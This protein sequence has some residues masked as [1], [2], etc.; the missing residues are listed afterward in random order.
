MSGAS[1]DAYTVDL[2]ALDSLISHMSQFTKATDTNVELID[3][4]VAKM[5]WEG[6]TEQAHKQWQARW[7]A[8]VEDLQEGLHTIREAAKTA[9]E[10]YTSAIEANVKMWGQ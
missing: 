2:E 7:R 4:Y 3:A 10:T 5:P 8:G 1:E 6:E 9:H